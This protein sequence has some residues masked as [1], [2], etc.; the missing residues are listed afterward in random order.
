MPQYFQSDALRVVA[1]GTFGEI[2]G[3]HAALANLL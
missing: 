1:I 3:G 2:H